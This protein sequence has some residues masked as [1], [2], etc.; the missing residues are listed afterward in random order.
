VEGVRNKYVYQTLLWDKLMNK[1]LFRNQKEV[2]SLDI[3]ARKAWMK[4]GPS[5]DKYKMANPMEVP[6]RVRDIPANSF[7]VD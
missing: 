4:P 3:E 2:D 1:R 6:D 5:K 7:N